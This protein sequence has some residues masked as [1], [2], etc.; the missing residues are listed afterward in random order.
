MWGAMRAIIGLLL[1]L[2]IL[3]IVVSP[4]V[5]LPLTTVSSQL[6]AFCVL[7]ALAIALVGIASISRS[8]Y[9]SQVYA[10][11]SQRSPGI[12]QRGLLDKICALLC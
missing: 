2:F 4:Y 9:F 3:A 6:D 10:F 11:G 1:V 7:S 8:V 5:D 12:H